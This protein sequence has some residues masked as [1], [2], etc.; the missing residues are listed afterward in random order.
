MLDSAVHTRG[1]NWVKRRQVHIRGVSLSAFVFSVGVNDRPKTL[2]HLLRIMLRVPTGDT[3]AAGGAAM[4]A[5]R[6]GV[7]ALVAR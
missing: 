6:E 4:D 7:G 5:A 2:R 3:R 1:W